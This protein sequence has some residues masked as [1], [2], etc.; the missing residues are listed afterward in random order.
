MVRKRINGV[1]H[2]TFFGDTNYG[3]SY[4]AKQAA[5]E[6]RDELIKQVDTEDAARYRL[7]NKRNKTGV[8]GVAW[9]P[10]SSELD[11]ESRK[12]SIRARATYPNNPNR[13]QTSS[14]SIYRYGLWNAYTGGVNWR[15]R[16]IHEGEP[17]ALGTLIDGFKFFI[18]HYLD[19]MENGEGISYSS[20][21]DALRE[22]VSQD[23]VPEE[24]VSY[25]K[26]K[27]SEAGIS[28]VPLRR[29]QPID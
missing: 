9:F 5:V 7:Q 12:H 19:V 14:W 25:T 29:Y 17:A 26:T 21:M 22:L 2:Q 1:L 28:I 6:F 4:Y 10:P 13:L 27:A 11:S 24:I 8:I 3:G 16:A 18:D 23:N 15:Y 20:M